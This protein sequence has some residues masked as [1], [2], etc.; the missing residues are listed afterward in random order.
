MNV[1]SYYYDT[2]RKSRVR[3]RNPGKCPEDFIRA[4]PTKSAALTILQ[5][6]AWAFS[7]AARDGK[8]HNKT[9][10]REETPG[11]RAPALSYPLGFSF[12]RHFYP[13]RRTHVR[14]EEEGKHPNQGGHKDTAE[15]PGEAV[16]HLRRG[17]DNGARGQT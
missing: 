9:T 6:D 2:L 17:Q 10:P 14:D 15:H 8:P 12:G 13:W 3:A 7:R 5:P 16:K 4:P 11:D 1:Q